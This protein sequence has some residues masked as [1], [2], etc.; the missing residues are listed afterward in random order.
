MSLLGAERSEP[1]AAIMAYEEC[2]ALRPHQRFLC[3]LIEDGKAKATLTKI[4]K[5]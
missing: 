3:R 1:T 5:S 2:S 4:V